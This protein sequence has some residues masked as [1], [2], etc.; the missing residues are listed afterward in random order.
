MD[1]SDSSLR[2]STN[3]RDKHGAERNGLAGER[4]RQWEREEDKATVTNGSY[5][6]SIPPACHSHHTP[7]S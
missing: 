1:L 6:Q 2:H 4:G 5:Y 3:F 7:G